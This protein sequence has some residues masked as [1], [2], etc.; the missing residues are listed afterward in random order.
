MLREFLVW[1]FKDDK[2]LNMDVFSV[3]HIL[4]TLIIFGV[5]IFLGILF[6]KKSGEAKEKFLRA[7]AII[8]LVLYVGDFFIQPFMHGDPSVVGEM[9]IDK[10]PF[11]ICT[12]MCPVIM[13]IQFNK[14]MS[15]CYEAAA[16]LAIVGPL[17]YL[18]YP[19]GALGDVSPFCYRIIQTCMYHGVV[20]CW[21][22]NMIALGKAKI[23]I[24]RCWKPLIGLGLIA[25]WATVGNLAYNV[26]GN[27]HDWFFLTGSSFS[28]AFPESMH[29]YLTYIMPFAVIAAIFAV[30]LCVYGV[31]YLT[32]FVK[33]KI[34]GGKNGG[35]DGS[36]KKE[37]EEK[38][39]TV[40]V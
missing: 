20:F 3:W 37:T 17:M 24:K 29:P 13:L 21:G 18:T 25:L 7:L 26:E 1:L 14:R 33:G 19:N 40:A 36:E 23:S 15:W 2:P 35:Q 10:L 27:T 34:F 22:F 5:T 38:K 12:I 39:E 4:Y 6:C 32:L 31:Y 16:L 28:Y 9:N 11:H 30:V 8:T